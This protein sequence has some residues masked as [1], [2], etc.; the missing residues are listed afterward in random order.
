MRLLVGILCS[1]LWLLYIGQLI[2][3]A[4]FAL[5]QRLG[6]QERPDNADSLVGGLELWAARW[7][8]LWLWTLPAAGILMLIDHAWWPYAALIGGGAY[9][10]TGGREGAKVLGLRQQGVRTGTPSEHRLAMGVF[11]LLIAIGALAIV[12]ALFT[13]I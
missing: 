12:T 9:I 3:T 2:S 1:A 7:D 11:A 6:L 5:A 4:N 13:M 8:L 10:D